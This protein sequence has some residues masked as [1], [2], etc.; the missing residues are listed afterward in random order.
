[1][2]N[3]KKKIYDNRALINALIKTITGQIE[4]TP[5]YEDVPKEEISY[6]ELM[7]E[8]EK[9][10]INNQTNEEERK[11]VIS[12]RTEWEKSLK[13]LDELREKIKKLRAE[14]DKAIVWDKE[15]NE[16]YLLQLELVDSLV[17][18]DTNSIRTEISQ[19]E[20]T[21]SKIRSNLKLNE[22]LFHLEV[23]QKES[24]KITKRLEEIEDEKVKLISSSRLPIQ[25][26]TFDN[27]GIFYNGV[28]FEQAS[29][30]EQLRTSVAMG[31]AMNPKLKILLIRDG[32]LLD[33]NNLKMIADMAEIEGGQLWLERVGEGKECQ[34]I[35]E[36]GRIK[37]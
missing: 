8:Q 24:D 37:E 23:R 22:L 35:I 10:I 13:Y 4:G 16:R 14:W 36:D 27:S 26:L 15:I 29:S 34:V 21:N 11:K 6:P 3:E 18:E 32:S 9:R 25:D 31:F 20:E 1:L 7:K 30:A 28:P 2:D 19:A 5:R 12:L 17:D 33:E